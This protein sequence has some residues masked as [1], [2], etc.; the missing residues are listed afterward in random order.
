MKTKI[1]YLFFA[2]VDLQER[3]LLSLHF[4]VRPWY[5]PDGDVP[6]QW[7][8]GSFVP[9]TEYRLD[10]ELAEKLSLYSSLTRIPVYSC[11][12]EA[13]SNW[14]DTVAV[15]RLALIYEEIERRRPNARLSPSEKELVAI[16]EDENNKQGQSINRNLGLNESARKRRPRPE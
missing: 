14:P 4:A 15:V 9:L 5:C 8:W 6:S 3:L 11:I 10:G 12:D 13:V 7:L 16:V 2:V 1:H